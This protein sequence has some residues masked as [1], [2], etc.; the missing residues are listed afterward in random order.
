MKTSESLQKGAD[1]VRFR[2]DFPF[3][4][5]LFILIV[6]IAL[7]ACYFFYTESV[8]ETLIFV[9]ATGAAAAGILAA[10]YVGRTLSLQLE[11]HAYNEIRRNDAA[12]FQKKV[13]AFQLAWRWTDPSMNSARRTCRE[14]A[15]MRRKSGDEIRSSIS[16]PN[17]IDDVIHM[18]NYL[19]EVSLGVR[20]KIVDEEMVK[21]FFQE[22]FEQIWKT[23]ELW[24]LDYRKERIAPRMWVDFEG[25][26]K[27][28]NI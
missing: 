21:E 6:T 17:Q 22:I 4:M 24:I 18:L 14:I 28:W 27:K 7:D 5:S 10:F 11:Q 19:E 16:D 23:L 15:N 26:N 20:K 9:A 8:P 2:V 1:E 13:A 12:E 25:L 3:R